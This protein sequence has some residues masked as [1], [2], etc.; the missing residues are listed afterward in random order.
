MEA[1]LERHSEG[2]Q[3]VSDHQQLTGGAAAYATVDGLK[4]YDVALLLDGPADR[5]DQARHYLDGFR[6]YWAPGI[7]ANVY[8]D[9]GDGRRSL[10]AIDVDSTTAAYSALNTSQRDGEYGRLR[11]RVSVDAGPDAAVRYPSRLRRRL[12]LTMAFTERE[13]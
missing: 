1:Q 2:A 4:G 12:P 9:W 10:R 3:E 6:P 11:V 5:I 8:Q 13:D 7:L